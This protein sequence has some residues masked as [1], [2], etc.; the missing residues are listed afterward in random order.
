[1]I[2]SLYGND[3]VVHTHKRPIL[4]VALDPEYH[5]KQT[6]RFVCGGRAGQ[7][8]LCSKGMCEQS[9]PRCR[10]RCVVFVRNNKRFG[11]SWAVLCCVSSECEQ[12]ENLFSW[13]N[14]SSAWLLGTKNTVLHQGEGTIYCAKWRGSYVLSNAFF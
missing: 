7:L 1:M 9:M 13:S 8:I 4:T 2:S 10:S 6:R 5:R 3:Q 12:Q 11:W 14:G